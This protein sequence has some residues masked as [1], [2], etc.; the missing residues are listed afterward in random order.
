MKNFKRLSIALFVVPTALSAA[1]GLV[2]API[3]GGES[4]TTVSSSTKVD[5]T[6]ANGSLTI[7]F[8]GVVGTDIKAVMITPNPVP[9][10]SVVCLKAN[11]K[12]SADWRGG[13]ILGKIAVTPETCSWGHGTVQG[14]KVTMTVTACPA[15]R[16]EAAAVMSGVVQLPDGTQAWVPHPAPYRVLNAKGVDA[17]AIGFNCKTNHVAPLGH[18]EATA[19]AKL[20]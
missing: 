4:A 2:P 12:Q 17:T 13:H 5:A 19:M 1:T 20:F 8:S 6:M 14:G 3:V 11:G 7:A 15:G 10:G 18:R 9:D 16:T